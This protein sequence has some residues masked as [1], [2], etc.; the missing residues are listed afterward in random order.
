MVKNHFT[1]CEKSG[2]KKTASYNETITYYKNLCKHNPSLTLSYF[3]KSESGVRLPVVTLTDSSDDEKFVVLIQNCIHPGEPEGNDATMMLVREL[4]ASEKSSEL[5]RRLK[6]VIIPILNVD[7]HKRTGKYNRVNQKGPLFQGWRTNARNLN[8]NRDYLKA[9]SEEIKS[10][11][12]LIAQLKP[13]IFVDNHTTNG[14]DYQYHI[15][16]SIE[17]GPVLSEVLSGFA[18]QSF[19]PYIQ[20]R[21]TAAGFKHTYYI[22]LAGRELEDGLQRI[23]GMPRFS[24][25]YMAIRNRIGLLVETHSLKPFENRVTSTLEINRAVIDFISE[26]S[27][28]IK[29]LNTLSEQEEEERLIN[30]KEKFAVDWIPSEQSV[31]ESFASV[32]HTSALSEITGSEV[33]RYTAQPAEVMVP[34][35]K[36]EKIISEIRLPEYYLIPAAFREI[37]F[38]LKLHGFVAQKIPL[39]NRVITRFRITSYAFETK[40][41][42]GRFRLSDFTCLP[43]ERQWYEQGE[44]LAYNTKQNNPRILG[45]LLDPR[46]PDSLF[47]WG[48]FNGIF[49]RKE[50]AE[51]FVFEPI[52]KKMLKQNPLL[53]EEF[54]QL[55]EIEEF[56]NSPSERLDFF[57]KNSPY[58]DKREGIYPVFFL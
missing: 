17:K 54:L 48:F 42:E 35:Y 32:T 22:E 19:L 14:L 7:G 8:L 41:Y 6:I 52:A 34:V 12:K 40:P 20:Q 39:K 50:Y 23:A 36:E 5:L 55:L 16:Y 1:P 18:H 11:L 13:D 28:V 53:R 15:T 30:K 9:D 44:Y 51:D 3:G 46:S 10:F 56:R 38:L 45:F 2:L 57:Y 26:N 58:F 27:H 21:L 33:K 43:E 31:A 47:Q 49:E 29:K 24:T 4:L 25:G 37:H